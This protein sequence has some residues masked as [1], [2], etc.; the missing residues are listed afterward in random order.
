[1]IVDTHCHLDMNEFDSDREEVISRAINTGVGKLIT[2]G[3]DL[4]SSQKAIE[5]S[6]DFKNV[7]ATVGIQPE[8]IGQYYKENSAEMGNDIRRDLEVLAKHPKVVA[9][10]EIGLDYKFIQ[11]GT[12]QPTSATRRVTEGLERERQRDI[13]RRQLGVS[14]LLNLPVIIH[15]READ[16]DL[17]TE[18]TKYKDTGRLKGVVH[19]FTGTLEL[20]RKIFDLGLL[21]SFTGIITFP[22][23][24][25]LR[26]VIKELPLE[27][28]MVETDSP[29][30]A[31]QKHRG[32][33][34]E[35]SFI[36][37]IIQEISKIKRIDFQK[38][39]EITTLNAIRLFDLGG[40]N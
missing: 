38:V 15:S 21:I 33:R 9:I 7:Y 39:E 40:K 3:V 10:G 2:V 19:C 6:K 31:P 4:K 30:L 35:P 29:L 16:K 37:E 13:F 36:N 1:M 8:E 25:N 22:N 11:A 14:I 20:A 12:P 17:V 18:L 23:A 26:N 28:I 5:I 32:S 24:A 27:K 34:N